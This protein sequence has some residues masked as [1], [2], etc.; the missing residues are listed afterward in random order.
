MEEADRGR[1]DAGSPVASYLDE[2]AARSERVLGERLVGVYAGGSLALGDYEP[3]RSD[4]D[5]AVVVDEELDVETKLG[6]VDALRHESLPCPARLLELVVYSRAAAATASVDAGFE[7]NLNS[8]AAMPFRVDLVPDPAET[9]WF[10]IDRAILRVHG[11]SVVGPPVGDVF[12]AIPHSWLLPVLAQSLRWHELG[13]AR[14]DDAVLNACRALRYARDD[15]WSS[16]P[17]AGRWALDHVADPEVVAE[18]LAARSGGPPPSPERAAAFVVA[19]RSEVES[20][21][22]DRL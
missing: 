19:A 2:L 20:G 17:A 16:K 1:P 3:G 8:G 5:V 22:R 6:L 4:I 21:Q 13:E 12:A 10:A 15:E 14:S 7:L 18:A 9:H 11:V